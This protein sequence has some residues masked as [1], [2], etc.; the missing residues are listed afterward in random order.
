M[1]ML[2]PL[3]CGGIGLLLLLLPGPVQ[4][5]GFS[6]PLALGDAPWVGEREAGGVRTNEGGGWMEEEGRRMREE[7]EDKEDEDGSG[8]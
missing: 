8:V 4:P 7:D 6:G 2:W 3:D 1:L 5:L